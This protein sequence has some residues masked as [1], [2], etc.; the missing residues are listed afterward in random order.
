MRGDQEQF[1]SPVKVTRRQVR[2]VILAIPY[3]VGSATGGTTQGLLAQI[4]GD[5][6][7]LLGRS[8][9]NAAVG[10]FQIVGYGAGGLLL[11]VLAPGELFLI[12]AVIDV[13]LL[14]AI[15]WGITDRPASQPTTGIV[16]RTRSI[17]RQLLGSPLTR[18][19]YLCL[20]VPNGLIVGCEALFVPHSTHAGFVFGVTAA[21]MLLGDI[22]M[23]RCIAPERRDRLVGP[24]RV[25]LAAPYLV[26]FLSPS[27]PILLVAAFT[28]AIG[29]AASLPLQ[30]RLLAHTDE[31]HRGQ[32]FGLAMNGMMIGQAVGAFLGGMLAAQVTTS[33]SMGILAASLLANA[34]LTP[35]LRR[36]AAQRQVNA[37]GRG[38]PR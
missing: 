12:A 18:P 5:E 27:L 21:G 31:D 22:T 30:D 11:A 23:G 25:L 20:R 37:A 24:L 35:G 4:V 10:V 34:A 29:Y 33:I 2:F 13:L 26:M 8:T 9:L 3:V 17:N 36:S 32:T 15:M 19:I 16:S 7:F 1:L 14:I 38:L 6:G 28:S